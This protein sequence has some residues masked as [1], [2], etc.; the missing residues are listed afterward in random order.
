MFYK[1][2]Y[3]LPITH[4]PYF[5][6]DCT[7]D[8][9]KVLPGIELYWILC[10]LNNVLITGLVENWDDRKDYLVFQIEVIYR[11]TEKL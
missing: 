3:P 5:T 8:N 7:K 1:T 6:P 11:R 2:H 10:Y 9:Y 4:Y